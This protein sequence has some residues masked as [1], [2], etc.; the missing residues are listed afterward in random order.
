MLIDLHAHTK[1]ISRCCKA[2]IERVI[3]EAKEKGISGVVLTNHYQKSYFKDSTEEEFIKS[4]TDEYY[5]MKSVADKHD[6]F[7]CFGIEVSMEQYPKVHMLIYGIEPSFL[8]SMKSLE[9][10]HFL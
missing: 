9:C 5:K 3:S 6:F 7:C 10:Q 8:D 4:Y 2:D 1:G